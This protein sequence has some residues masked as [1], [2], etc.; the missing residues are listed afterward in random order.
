[1]SIGERRSLE[2]ER[3]AAL[4]GS[5]DQGTHAVQFYE[6]SAAL[7][8]KLGEFV[9]ASLGTGGSC[10]V[11]VSKEHRIM[12]AERLHSWGVDLNRALRAGRYIVLDAEECLSKFM[13]RS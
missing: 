5:N 2:R 7:I 10:V 1:M 13:V 6:A 3:E 4:P 8:E 9:G 11:I 12:L